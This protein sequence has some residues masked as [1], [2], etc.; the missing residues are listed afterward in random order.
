MLCTMTR[1]ARVPAL[2]L[3]GLIAIFVPV[4]LGQS[5]QAPPNATQHAI[6]IPEVMN[7]QG[8]GADLLSRDGRWLAYRATGLEGDG[9]VHFRQT[10]GNRDYHFNLGED[11]PPAGYGQRSPDGGPGSVALSSDGR[12]G[13]FL[14]EPTHAEAERLRRQHKPLETHAGLVDLSNGQMIEF[15]RVRRFEFSGDN[16]G[17]IVL[18]K[19]GPEPAA[20]SAGAGRGART[21]PGDT[22]ESDP[23]DSDLI[24][25]QLATGAEYNLGHVGEFAFNRQ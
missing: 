9:T 12:W 16:P 20:P 22:P 15:A 24:L 14:A 19:Y 11:K 10:R 6:T 17:W 2:A 13:A 23:H 8:I 18:Q 21:S 3:G 5:G 4:S 7:F 1:S 25:R